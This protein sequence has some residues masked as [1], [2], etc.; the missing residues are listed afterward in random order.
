MICNETLTRVHSLCEKRDVIITCAVSGHHLLPDRIE[1]GTPYFGKSL[2]VRLRTVNTRFSGVYRYIFQLS[3]VNSQFTLTRTTTVLCRHPQPNDR[4][5]SRETRQAGNRLASW[6]T[7]AQLGALQ[8]HSSS[9][10]TQRTYSCSN[11]VAISSLVLE[12][13]NKCRV[14]WVLGHPVY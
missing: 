7:A 4:E 5:V 2:P 10:L 1:P 11:L 8:T 12:L 6:W 14:W 3:C 9:F 13:L